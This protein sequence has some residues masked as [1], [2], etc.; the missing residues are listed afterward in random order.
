VTNNARVILRD[1]RPVCRNTLRGFAVVEVPPGLV[2]ENVS[3]HK[4]GDRI[5]VSLP[6][7]PLLDAEGRHMIDADGKKRYAPLLNWTSRELADRFS[8]A[9]I[10][11]V[12]RNHDRLD[13]LVEPPRAPRQGQ[14]FKA[15]A[16]KP[17][18]G[19]DLP[20]DSVADLWRGEP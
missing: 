3:L 17:A 18:R 7:R 4:K 10:D 9:V 13:D 12:R 2:I 5:W 11:L 1:F 16:A 20:D 8:R 15:P 19:P 6:A 14:L